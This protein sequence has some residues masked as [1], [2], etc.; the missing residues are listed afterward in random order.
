MNLMIEELTRD[1]MRR[2]LRDAE[3]RRA[4]SRSRRRKEAHIVPAS[5][6]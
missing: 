6:N 2:T 1:R 4:A 3:Q 5:T